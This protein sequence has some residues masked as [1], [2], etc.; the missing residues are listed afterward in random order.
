MICS[1]RCQQQ[2][3]GGFPA[4]F[5]AT[6]RRSVAN[7]DRAAK[8]IAYHMNLSFPLPKSFRRSA[9][10]CNTLILDIYP[11]TLFVVFFF[12]FPPFSIPCYHHNR[13]TW[14]RTILTDQ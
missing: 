10:L 7:R 9:H 14:H 11:G 5:P 8:I 2:V 12:I 4:P 1:T 6:S 3:D 13:L